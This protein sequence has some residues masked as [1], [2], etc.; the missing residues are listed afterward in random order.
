[1]YLPKK[2]IDDGSDRSREVQLISYSEADS[3]HYRRDLMAALYYYRLQFD[4]SRR[5]VRDFLADWQMKTSSVFYSTPGNVV[6][7]PEV[8]SVFPTIDNS[9]RWIDAFSRD[10]SLSQVPRL[11]RNVFPHIQLIDAMFRD[12]FPDVA[13]TFASRPHVSVGK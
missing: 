6:D 2:S 10:V 11:Y 12:R 7:L 8:D 3:K 1:M 4:I 13:Q 9:D 5:K